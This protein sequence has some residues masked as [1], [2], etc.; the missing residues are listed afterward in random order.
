MPRGRRPRRATPSLRL[1]RSRYSSLCPPVWHPPAW[2]PG[3]LGARTDRRHRRILAGGF[4]QLG[5]SA[6]C[7][8]S[9]GASGILP[10]KGFGCACFGCGKPKNK[11]GISAG[12]VPLACGRDAAFCRVEKQRRDD[13][14]RQFQFDAVV[15]GCRRRRGFDQRPQ[16][17]PGEGHA[18]ALQGRFN[19][20][21]RQQNLGICQISTVVIS[22]RSPSGQF[23]KARPA[24]RKWP[25]RFHRELAAQPKQSL[26]RVSARHY[27]Y[28]VAWR[29]SCGGLR[30]DTGRGRHERWRCGEAE[31]QPV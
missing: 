18:S 13:F 21:R 25:F 30:C 24:A 16:V 4:R 23:L 15:D 27:Y 22:S 10:E 9:G 17:S 31:G 26:R 19:Q 8:V 2:P 12:G 11:F 14:Q 5:I 6:G 29:S 20:I 7:A 28:F 3:R 1:V